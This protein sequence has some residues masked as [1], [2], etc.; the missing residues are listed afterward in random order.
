MRRLLLAIAYVRAFFSTLQYA[1]YMVAERRRKIAQQVMRLAKL[2]GWDVL[3]SDRNEY[4]LATVCKAP[5]VGGVYHIYDGDELAY[6]GAV[7]RRG[8]L[9][10]RLKDHLKNRESNRALVDFI[11]SGEASVEW[12]ACQAPGWMEDYELTE[13]REKHGRLPRFNKIQSGIVFRWW[14]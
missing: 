6:I 10:E 3:A 8:G 9:R 4:S 5:P 11:A 1:R 2:R 14:W 13:Y 7:C 12:Y